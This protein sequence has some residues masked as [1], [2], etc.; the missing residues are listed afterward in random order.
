[1]PTSIFTCA[2][3]D[4]SAAILEDAL[5]FY[6]QF[7]TQNAANPRLQHDT[8]NAHGEWGKSMSDSVSMARQR[9]PTAGQSKSTTP[10]LSQLAQDSDLAP[11]AT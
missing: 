1:M 7:A 2:V 4:K 10:N 3:S 9:T 8:A 5:V 11:L 6:D